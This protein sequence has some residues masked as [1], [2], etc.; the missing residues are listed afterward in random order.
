MPSRTDTDGHTKACIYPLMEANAN[1]LVG[2]TFTNSKA[3]IGVYA[4]PS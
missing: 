3:K 1:I 4:S 2:P